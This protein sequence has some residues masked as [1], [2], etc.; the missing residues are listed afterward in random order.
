MP[1]VYLALVP[2]MHAAWL[3]HIQG[4]YTSYWED[5]IPFWAYDFSQTKGLHPAWSY[6]KEPN[7]SPVGSFAANG[8]GLYDMVGNVREW[9][10]A[11]RRILFTTPI[12]YINVYRESYPD[13]LLKIGYQKSIHTIPGSLVLGFSI[14]YP[15]S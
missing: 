15:L 12:D 13:G 3:T 10:I 9:C 2:R 5:G 7:T 1:R 11:S 8:F 6:G 4:N 14:P